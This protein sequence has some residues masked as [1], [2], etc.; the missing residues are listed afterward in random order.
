MKRST[1]RI[2]TTPT[3]SLPRPNWPGR[4]LRVGEAVIGGG[5]SSE[6]QDVGVLRRIVGEF[7]R[8]MA[9]DCDVIR[10]GRLAVGDPVELLDAPPR[11]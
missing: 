3:G 1:D 2:L 11:F 10:R 4:P 7:G 8:R 6:T 5:P 9:L